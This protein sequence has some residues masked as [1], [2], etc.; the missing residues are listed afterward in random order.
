MTALG[1]QP[2]GLGY[3]ALAIHMLLTVGS[4]REGPQISCAILLSFEALS[5]VTQVTWC[6]FVSRWAG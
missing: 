5:S 4:S 3:L 1:L 2:G 6:P